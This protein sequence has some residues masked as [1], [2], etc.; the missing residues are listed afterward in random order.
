MMADVI[1]NRLKMVNP[2]MSYLHY[3]GKHTDRIS[4]K[5]VGFACHVFVEAVDNNERVFL[6]RKQHNSLPIIIMLIEIA[7]FKK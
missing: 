5:Q 7:I 1:F 4:A 6:G 2:K 3:F